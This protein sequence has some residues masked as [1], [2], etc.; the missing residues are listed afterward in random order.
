MQKSRDGSL[1][2]SMNMKYGGAGGKAL[3]DSELTEECFGGKHTKAVLYKVVTT[4][5]VIWH[6]GK[7]STVEEDTEKITCDCRVHLGNFQY[8]LFGGRETNPS[9]HF[10]DLLVP[11]ENTP[12]SD[13]EGKKITR[14]DG[15]AKIKIG[16]AGKAKG[17]VQVLWERGL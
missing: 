16:Y 2:S 15:G 10:N 4:D 7:P 5:Q 11:L 3:R 12:V 6:H 17:I 14:K 9:P 1:T 8:F 13:K